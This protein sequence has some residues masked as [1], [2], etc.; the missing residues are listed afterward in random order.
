MPLTDE[1]AEDLYRMVRELHAAM[2]ARRAA[3][4]TT[5]P[6]RSAP[7]PEAAPTL[8]DVVRSFAP[9]AA[10]DPNDPI[11]KLANATAQRLAALMGDEEE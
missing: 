1:Q 10:H 2:L 9:K 5:S 4:A 11:V 8:G 3:P 7:I 6:R